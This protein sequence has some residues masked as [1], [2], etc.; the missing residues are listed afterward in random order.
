MN[1]AHG[2]NEIS[3]RMLKLCE[4]AITKLLHLIFKNCLCSS[5]LP[6]VWK[7]ANVIPVHNKGDK[8]VLKNYGLVP[9]LPICGKIFEKL[10]FN[11]LYSFF[12]D[13]KLL[14]PC[15]SGFKK[16]DSCINQLVSI[17]HEIYSA[18]DCNPS[19]EV[20]GVFLDLSKAFDKVWHDGLIYKLKSLGI[21]GNLLKLIQNYLD[22]RFQRVLLN[23]QTSEWKPVKAGVPQGSILGP[24][25]FLVYIN[26]ICSN[27]STNVKLFAD[28]TSLFSIVNDANKSF[29]NLSNDLCIISNWAYQW[30]MSFNPDISKQAR[31]VI[32]SRKT[33]IQSHPVLTFDNS[34]VIKT[35][36][37]KHLGLILDEK[38]NFKEH[39]KEKMSKAYKGI[40]VLRKL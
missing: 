26:D 15:Q 20:R 3:I 25:F 29:E 13:H 30:K 8:Q 16:N 9:L 39:L 31:E 38:L 36:H 4:S 17:T 7:K 11:A 2:Y 12:E 23:G 14:N 37:H 32:F 40:A 19:L 34:P 6:D 33:S 10:I 5:A 27:L 1:K 22:N 21:S 35:T 18:F 24:L 28:D